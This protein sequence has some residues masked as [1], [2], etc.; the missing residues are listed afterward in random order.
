M[1]ARATAPPKK[2]AGQGRG[3]RRLDGDIRDVASQAAAWGDTEK[4]IRSK[5]ARRLIPFRQ[6]GGRIV[7]LRSEM[8]EFV[9]Q[10]PGVSLDEALA[11]VRARG[12]R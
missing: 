1:T 12:S 7:F 5:V 11:N 6:L 9:R 4:G 3:A 8:D 10:L 2:R